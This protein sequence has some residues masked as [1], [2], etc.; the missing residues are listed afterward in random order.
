MQRSFSSLRFRL[1]V[2]IGGGAPSSKH[3]IRLGDVVVS[4]PANGGPAVIHYEFGKTVQDREFKPTGIL[5]SPPTALLTVLSTVEARHRLRGHR[6][7]HTISKIGR[8]YPLLKA[9]IARPDEFTDILIKSRFMHQD[10]RQSCQDL[11]CITEDNTISR[12]PRHGDA[13]DPQIHYGLIASADRVMKM[14]ALAID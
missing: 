1:M 11:G 5:A 12:L 10:P 8:A 4:S 9:T 13:N 7:Q 2:G 14:L 6:I 3:D